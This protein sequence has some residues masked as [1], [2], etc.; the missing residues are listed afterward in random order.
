MPILGERLKHAWNAFLGRDPTEKIW[1][2]FSY[3]SR[4]DRRRGSLTNLKLMVSSIY[5]Q[6]AVD[7]SAISIRHVKLDDEGKFKETMKSSLN[8]VLTLEANVDQTGRD[9]IK[10]TVFS[11]LDEGCVA[12]VP[13][14]TDGN[15]AQTD[16]YKILS[17]RVG[18]IVE[19]FP[20]HI[21]VNV[22]N[23]MTGN[24]E[25]LMF[26]K[27]VACIIENPF[28]EIMNAPNSTAKRLLRIINQLDKA[29][30]YSSSGR[31][32]LIIQL[33][34]VVKTPAQ[35]KQAENRR[36]SIEAQLVG[37]AHGIA[38]TDGTERIVQLNR[39]V[40]NTLWEQA[41]ELEAKLYNQLGFSQSIFDGTADE[42]TMLNYYNRT[43]EPILSTIVENMER[44]WISKTARSQNQAIR[45]FREPF[46]LVPVSQLADIA[47]K[48]TRNEIM[49][50]NEF[51]AVI[52]LKPADD[53]KADELR[54]SNL[55]H[56]DEQQSQGSENVVDQTVSNNSK[57]TKNLS[58]ILEK[59]SNRSV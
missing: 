16:S 11:T 20:R 17:L 14:D 39:P 32:D 35:K 22:Y 1:P 53:P 41:K 9:L 40:E 54:N 19:W 44:K 52:G 24:Y 59:V 38:Y 30:D 31:L 33:P 26:E 29:N 34:Y 45:F 21:L 2:G 5:N 23:D 48:F 12:I 58:E 50:S 15:P 57:S 13:I 8:R 42:K 36:K 4:P 7:C 28:Y 49:S 18:K 56:P 47:D 46:K 3:A 37:S 25:D 6:I 55:N 43:I 10:D 51:R 27:R